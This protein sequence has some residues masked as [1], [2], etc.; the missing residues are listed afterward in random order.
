MLPWKSFVKT[1]IYFQYF[2]VS[3]HPKTVRLPLYCSRYGCQCV[4]KTDWFFL[5][6]CHNPSTVTTSLWFLGHY[7]SPLHHFLYKFKLIHPSD[8]SQID[9]ASNF[10]EAFF[11]QTFY[12]IFSDHNSLFFRL[13]NH[14]FFLET[15]CWDIYFIARI[16]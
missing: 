9:L 14:I 5:F 10:P 6:S 8:F 3:A 4:S 12:I 1:M 13:M 11:C 2:F 15:F 16:R 7:F